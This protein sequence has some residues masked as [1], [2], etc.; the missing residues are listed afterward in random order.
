MSDFE[1]IEKYLSGKLSAEEKKA[2]RNRLLNDPAFNQEFQELK[3]I[4][5]SVKQKARQDVKDLFN[6]FEMRIEK[7]ETT[8][9]QTVMKKSNFN[10]CEH[11]AHSSNHLC[12]VNQQFLPQQPRIIRQ[13]LHNLQQLGWTSEG[14]GY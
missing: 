8:K 3:D 9:D 7:E 4:R 12:W 1:L 5:L 10:R 6:E 14:C 11:S 13:A 2:F